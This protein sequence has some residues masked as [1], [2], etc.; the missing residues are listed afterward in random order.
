M[1]YP[2]SDVAIESTPE[3]I[4][5]YRYIDL[6]EE[7]YLIMM[8]KFYQNTSLQPY[9]TRY[10]DNSSNDEYYI[11]AY[12]SNFGARKFAHHTIDDMAFKLNHGRE[13]SNLSESQVV[14]TD[15][16]PRADILVAC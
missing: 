3:V 13:Y 6:S 2:L 7:V 11:W 4:L 16:L 5:V 12:C 9:V 10:P 1:V 14:P 15:G 8:D